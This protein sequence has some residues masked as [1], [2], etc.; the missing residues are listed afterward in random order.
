MLIIILEKYF[1]NT[2]SQWEHKRLS[3]LKRHS[4][5]LVKE[6]RKY[7]EEMITFNKIIN[8]STEASSLWQ[9][10]CFL[11][12][13][14]LSLEDEESD[15]QTSHL[16]KVASLTPCGYF[17]HIG[18]TRADLQQRRISDSDRLSRGLT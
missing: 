7:A 2:Q 1:I 13:R 5:G 6:R 18:Q 11:I 8:I 15:I 12:S 9:M 3:E 14:I 10:Y 17:L 16:T 4:S